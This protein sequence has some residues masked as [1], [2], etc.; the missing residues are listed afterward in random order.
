MVDRSPTHDMNNKNCVIQAT[1]A[2]DVIIAP[3]STPSF[4]AFRQ[5]RVYTATHLNRL[6]K[7][8]CCMQRAK[9]IA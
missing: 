9:L 6:D 1:L 4:G 3:S 8:A 7:P 5:Y 2:S